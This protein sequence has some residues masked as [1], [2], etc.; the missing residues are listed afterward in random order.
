[1]R[2]PATS[3]CQRAATAADSSRVTEFAPKALESMCS[4]FMVGLGRLKGGRCRV[5]AKSGSLR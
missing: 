5:G 2:S 3:S 4:S 1:M